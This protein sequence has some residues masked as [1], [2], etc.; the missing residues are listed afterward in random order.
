MRTA[1]FAILSFTA[2]LGP[3]SPAVAQEAGFEFFEKKIRPLLTERCYE[4]HSAEKKIKG[5][6]RL[7]LA[8]GWLK[9]GDSGPAVMPGKVDDSPLIKAIRYSGVDFEAMP[10]KSARPTA[11]PTH[12]GSPGC[13]RRS[14]KAAASW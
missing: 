3:A 7:D 12:A 8:D 10:P 9:G 6:L 2:A 14:P 13:M 11:S 1:F 4:C 5:G